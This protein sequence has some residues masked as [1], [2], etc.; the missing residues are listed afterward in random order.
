MTG[1]TPAGPTWDHGPVRV[2]T[3]RVW[4]WFALVWAV[5]V[6]VLVVVGVHNG[7]ITAKEQ[8][9]VS[10]AL[11]IVDRT[12]ADLSAVLA[13]ATTVVAIGP[14][15]LA[16]EGCRITPVRAGN[17]Y[18]RVLTVYA[19]AG[20][21]QGLLAGVAENLPEHYATAATDRVLRADAG[22][23]VTVRGEAGTSG[24][25]RFVV[26]AGCR[27]GRYSDRLPSPSDAPQ[28][29]RELAT[30]AIDLLGG[31]A[32]K[33]TARRLDCP[34]V[35]SGAG[36]RDRAGSP[37]VAG[38]VGWTYRTL[39]RGA[40]PLTALTPD[41]LAGATIVVSGAETLAYRIGQVEV[42]VSRSGETTSVEATSRCQN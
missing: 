27:P 26:D 38:S 6:G 12:I 19:A 29:V 40:G 5:V 33:R 17:R 41:R 37:E 23:F 1:A 7:E 36:G 31:V 28:Q 16:T 22:D 15:E 39:L 42:A 34:G 13:P 4:P 21:E 9:T 30:T 32:S 24:K 20:T 2:S 35:G 10:E 18:Q 11:P 3:L 14:Y 8:S 25:I